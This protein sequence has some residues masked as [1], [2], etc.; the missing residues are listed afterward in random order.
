MTIIQRLTAALL[1]L[2][3]CTGG[4]AAL[5][6]EPAGTDAPEGLLFVQSGTS[7]TVQGEILTV[8]G[9]ADTLYFTDKP[10]R[11][12]GILASQEFIALWDAGDMLEDPPNAVL[13]VP[14]EDPF[15][16]VLEIVAAPVP[17][18]DGMS[19][20]VKVLWGEL[21]AGGGPCSLFVD[22]EIVNPQITDAD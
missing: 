14:G 16:V 9:V 21:P 22:S 12:A 1:A 5:A 19:Y 7:F 4:G 17:Q 13:S 3:L 18:G 2:T 20:A 10:E 8:S 11:K 15:K 6:E